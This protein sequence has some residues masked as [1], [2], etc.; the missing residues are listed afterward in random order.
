MNKGNNGGK[1][2]FLQ[3]GLGSHSDTFITHKEESL[4]VTLANAGFDVWLG[5]NRGNKYCRTNTN[6]DIDPDTNPAA[7]FDYS[8]YELGKYDAPT[9]I[10]FVLGKTGR[11]KL[12]YVG[13]SQGTSQMFSAL[14]EHHGDLQNKVEFFIAL[15]PIVNLA[16]TTTEL[17]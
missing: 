9:Q 4:S 13:H 15:A 16:H 11:S 10:D 3:H 17:F 14:S 12:T 6:P 7:F 8:F 5:N 2:V 1:V